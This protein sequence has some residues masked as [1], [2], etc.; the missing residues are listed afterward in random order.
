MNTLLYR[1]RPYTIHESPRAKSCVELTYRH[2]HYN[3][4]REQLRLEMQQNTTL[5]YRGIPYYK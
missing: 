1:G 4:C 2:E 3:T 5:I